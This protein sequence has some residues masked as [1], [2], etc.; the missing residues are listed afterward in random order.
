MANDGL[1]DANLAS[2][3]ISV[4]PTNHP[5]VAVKD[6]ATLNENASIRLGLLTND[7]DADGDALSM[8][9]ETQPVHGK[10]VL[11]ADNTV[12]YTPVTYFSGTDSFSY[13]LSDGQLLSGIATV[14]LAINPIAN[15][16]TLVLTE[17][18][19]SFLAGLEDTAIRLSAISAALIDTDGSE[20][21]LLRIENIPVGAVLTDGNHQFTAAQGATNA[22][23]TGWALGNLSVTPPKDFNGSFSL[24]VAA[25]A[26]EQLNGDQAST[27][28]TIKVIVL[29]VKDAPVAK[30]TRFTGQQNGSIAID[31]ASLISDADS[32]TLTPSFTKPLQGVL[33]KNSDGSYAY[34]P[35]LDFTGAD[36]F[37]Y[38]VSDGSLST[39][40]TVSLQVASPEV[41]KGAAITLQSGYA[42]DTPW[43]D[44]GGGV[45]VPAATVDWQGTVVNQ[46]LTS[47]NEWLVAYIGNETKQKTLV[48]ITGLTVKL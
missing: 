45:A 44:N 33:K 23:V 28:A 8:I 30:N 4:N 25:I 26:K 35:N 41:N 36:S 40:A 27:S 3:T 42:F 11:N 24:T 34:A 14:T 1:A 12:T 38:T 19:E 48:E 32:D 18:S 7:S 5:P 16:P 29:P 20:S 13:R 31:F 46:P 17:T 22:D 10:L 39:T 21:L 15:A 2:V 6:T 47:N 37:S 43:V 9:I